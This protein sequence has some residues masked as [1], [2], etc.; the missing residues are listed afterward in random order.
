MIRRA[1]ILMVALPVLAAAAL[2]M[3]A[4]SII[5]SNLPA[6]AVAQ[7]GNG[8]PKAAAATI[9]AGAGL[10]EPSGR[11]IA[12]ATAV[13]GVVRENPRQ[14]GRSCADRRY[15]VPVDD[16]ILAATLEQRRQDLRAAE[17]RLMQTKGR[18][19]QLRAES[20]A[21]QGVV[22]AARADR[23]DAKDQVDAGAQLVGGAVSQRELTRRRNALRSAEGRLVEA[24]ARLDGTR[25]ALALIDPA[26]QGA[27]YLAD[28]RPCAGR[29]GGRTGAA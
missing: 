20:E 8:Q 29:S 14:A 22:E 15:S 26:Q 7:S 25:A 13:A 1:R 17:L 11:E 18:V 6:P 28:G 3:A 21:A 23:D 4:L 10:V 27:T 2:T 5:R 19:D 16:S 12:V 9:V 24:M